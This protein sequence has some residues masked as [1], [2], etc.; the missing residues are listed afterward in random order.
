MCSS[1]TCDS[2]LLCANADLLFICREQNSLT[3]CAPHLKPLTLSLYHLRTWE[4]EGEI[5][6][7]SHGLK[8]RVEL[9]LQIKCTICNVVL[10]NAL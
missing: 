10:S 4:G 5:E 1:R 2:E 9:L 3:I 8:V 7:E 6:R